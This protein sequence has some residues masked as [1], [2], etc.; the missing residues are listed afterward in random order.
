MWLLKT[1]KSITVNLFIY[2]L[3]II[4]YVIY[5]CV[6]LFYYYFFILFFYIYFFCFFACFAYLNMLHLFINA[7]TYLVDYRKC[8]QECF[9][10]TLTLYNNV[11]N[12]WQKRQ[13]LT[14]PTS[15]Y[16]KVICRSECIVN[17]PVGLHASRC[18]FD[19][20]LVKNGQKTAQPVTE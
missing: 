9:I 8:R 3:F 17:S 7:F 15:F 20:E 1:R 4:C 14:S 11:S 10:I 5:L 13:E 16:V 2:L 6:Y 19:N 18:N 12:V